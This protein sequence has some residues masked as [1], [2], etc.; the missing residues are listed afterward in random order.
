MMSAHENL[1]NTATAY[2]ATGCFWGAE[3]RFWQMA[4]V[5]NTSVGYMGGSTSTP[6]YKE[7][8][9]G[10][11]GHAEVVRVE[12]DPAQIS[13]EQ[14][15]SAFWEMHD[16]TTLNRQGNDVGTQY[17]SAIFFVDENQQNAAQ[18]SKEI[19]QREL[20]RLGFDSIT[21]EITLAPSYWAAEE[22][23][24]RYLEKNPNGY[25]C[26]ATTGVP[27][28]ALVKGYSHPIDENELKSRVDNLSFNV[29][30][31]AA[32][33]APF[34]GEYTDEESV[35]VYRCKACNSEL[36]RSEHKF[37]SGCGWPSFYQPTTNDAV[38]L[39]AD[40]SLGRVRTE[41]RCARCG[42]HL[43]H[44]FEG[45]GYDTPTDERWCINSVS[46]VLEKK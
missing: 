43:G 23:H 33:E 18:Q 38:E 42:S 46:L 45:E 2:F 34:S 16:P 15:L 24:Q 11:T 32:T 26:H 13:Y 39:I 5:L 41:V 14:L 3:R 40:H 8:C 19:Y 1:S 9:T 44:V 30:R 31:R 12:F 21:T 22:Y 20:D 6:T 25:D 4:G 35:G 7:V 17:R 37:H 27:F 10:A 36:F 29:L 28:P